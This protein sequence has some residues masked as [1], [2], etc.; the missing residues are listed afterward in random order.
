MK[1]YVF[2]VKTHKRVFFTL[3]TSVFFVHTYN[4]LRDKLVILDFCEVYRKLPNLS[5]CLT[6]SV[7]YITVILPCLMSLYVVV[8]T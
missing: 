7:R 3:N 5:I 1:C 8:P 4:Y 2:R 6:T